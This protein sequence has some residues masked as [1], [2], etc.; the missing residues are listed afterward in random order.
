[1]AALREAVA[2]PTAPDARKIIVRALAST[3][4]LLIATA[5]P[6]LGDL[7]D[8]LERLGP[9]FERLCKDPNKRDPQC[10]GKTAIVKRLRDADAGDDELF[11]RGAR[12][13]QHEPVWGGKVDSAAELRGVCLMALAERGHPRA[14]VEAAQGLADPEVATRTATARAIAASGNVEVGEPLLR[15][16]IA[17]GE[18][19]PDVLGECL[20]AL[21]QLASRS[22]LPFV[23]ELLRSS[24]EAIVEAAALALGE[25]RLADALVPLR[26]RVELDVL[27]GRRSVLMLG[28]A[29]LRTEAAWAA[30]L[31][32]IEDGSRGEAQDA[33]QALATFAHDSGLATRVRAAVGG[34][35]DD[36]LVGALAELFG[37]DE[38]S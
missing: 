21:L 1:M 36:A 38:V 11:V 4:G 33:L 35:P 14:M 18:P 24:D 3:S 16:R 15:L 20:V 7:P 22:G 2:D 12:Y 37:S 17:A 9:A 8:L 25:S 28:I 31:E 26:E 19:D 6:A 13:V 30:L 23:A 5:I 27:S 10:T 29:M 32:W 34:R